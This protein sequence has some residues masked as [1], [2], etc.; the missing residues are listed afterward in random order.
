MGVPRTLPGLFGAKGRIFRAE[1]DREERFGGTGV[2]PV[3]AKQ[4]GGTPV[5]PNRAKD[6][7]RATSLYTDSLCVTQ[8]SPSR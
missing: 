1:L 2:P 5:P 7:Y 6:T 4:T 3:W 8:A